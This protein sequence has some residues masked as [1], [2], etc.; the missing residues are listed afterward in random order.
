MTT[1]AAAG[2]HILH[3]EEVPEPFWRMGGVDAAAWAGR[4]P[5]SFALLARREP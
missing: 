4:L 1:L 2:L 3:L 5:N